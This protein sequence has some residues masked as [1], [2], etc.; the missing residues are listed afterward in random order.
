MVAHLLPRWDNPSCRITW[1]FNLE[2]APW[3]YR[4]DSSP[5]LNDVLKNDW[6]K[7]ID[8]Y[9]AT[10]FT[11]DG[12]NE[13]AFSR[14]LEPTTTSIPKVPIKNYD[15]IKRQT[16]VSKMV[17]H[18]WSRWQKEYLT[19]LRERRPKNPGKTSSKIS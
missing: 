12:D 9:R 5:R 16:H 17:D 8:Y 15:P 10:N 14:R 11:V 19:P 3:V 18:F 13:L 6:F 4:K 2:C 1:K 7:T